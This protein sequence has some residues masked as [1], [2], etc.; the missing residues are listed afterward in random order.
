M[1]DQ[2]VCSHQWSST[3]SHG[4]VSSLCSETSNLE[5]RF[6]CLPTF[7]ST[8]YMHRHTSQTFHDM[9]L[10]KSTW[11]LQPC[12]TLSHRS[13]G[14]ASILWRCCFIKCFMT[15]CRD[16]FSLLCTRGYM[17]LAVDTPHL[18][19]ASNTH[20]RTRQ[21][22]NGWILWIVPQPCCS[23]LFYGVHRG[24]NC[25]RVFSCCPVK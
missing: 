11:R 8:V 6:F 16:R 2:Q 15:S 4:S 18:K 13:S 20:Y 24:P 9:K 23:V 17:T 1:C 12:S 10:Q 21:R 7:Y 22:V 5:L 3:S 14:H 25:S 19:L